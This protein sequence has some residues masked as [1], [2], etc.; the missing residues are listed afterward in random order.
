ME[1]KDSLLCSQES[2]TITYP[3]P[4]ESALHLISTRSIS[5]LS[6]HL[7]LGLLSDFSL[8]LCSPNVIWISYHPHVRYVPC[9]SH[10]PWFDHPSN[11]CFSLCSDYEQMSCAEW[12]NPSFTMKINLNLFTSLKSGLSYKHCWMAWN[13]DLIKIYTYNFYLKYFSMC[14]I[15]SERQGRMFLTVQCDYECNKRF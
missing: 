3:K 9:L 5:I 1:H 8:R 7:C 14:R 11:I 13:I 2:A 4:D 15:F 10:P 6:S 12:C